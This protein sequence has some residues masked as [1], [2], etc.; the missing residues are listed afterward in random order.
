MCK[1]LKV[2]KSGY[3]KW[4]NPQPSRRVITDE[5]LLQEIKDIFKDSMGNYGSPRIT[6]ELRE[7]GYKVG[8][9]RVARIMKEN[10]IF[11]QVKSQFKV[12]TTDSNHDLPISPNLLKQN[13]NVDEANTVWA[14]DITYIKIA[15]T[16]FYLCV[17]LD[18]FNREVV[19]YTLS[20][21]MKSSMVVETLHKAMIKKQPGRGLIFHSDRGSQFA[22]GEFRQWLKYYGFNQSMSGKG[23]CY[24]NAPVESFFG[25]FKVE[26]VYKN[27][28]K[29]FEYAQQRIFYY[30]EIFYNRK[31]KHSWNKGKSPF[32]Y[33]ANLVA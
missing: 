11:V 2:S 28:Y 3:Y 21:H 23:N 6:I 19:G 18:L 17:I 1:V 16:W 12:Q 10:R 13:F 9:N 5:Q 29:T 33:A 22:S 31:R 15:S 30:I 25:R 32:Q 24:D 20:P 26:E 14:S 7:R 27:I 4:V 8:E